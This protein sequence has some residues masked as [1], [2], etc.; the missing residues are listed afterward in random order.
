MRMISPWRA[1]RR[2]HEINLSELHSEKISVILVD[3]DNTLTR[4][5]EDYIAPDA[6]SWIEQAKQDGFQVIIL[7]NNR[8]ARVESFARR[9]SV[10]GIWNATK[11]NPLTYRRVVKEL[12]A[13]RKEC[14]A[15]GDQLFTDILGGNLAGMKT[16]L[17]DPS[18]M[19]EHRWTR[20]V[21]K[22]EKFVAHRKIQW[23]E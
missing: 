15:V 9:F 18:S 1:V 19:E 21:R 12:G 4:G 11:P 6:V 22:I 3:V 10:R 2:I 5:H 17:V 13:A 8:Q 20:F 7:S 14:A 16:I 23:D